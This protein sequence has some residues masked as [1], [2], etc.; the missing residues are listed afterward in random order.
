MSGTTLVSGT[1]A[2]VAGWYGKIPALGDFASRRLPPDFLNAWDAWLQRAFV[3]SRASLREHWQDIYLSSPIWRFALLPG[4]CDSHCW[5]GILMPSI[6]KV[7]RHFPLTIAVA[8]DPQP[9]MIATVFAANDWFTAIEQI[10]LSSLSMD[11]QAVELD[12]Q[13]A[14]M[15]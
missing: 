7:G 15:P 10:A 9:E 5:A 8:L 13:L 12:N 6:D 2:P 3:T 14:A 4:V 11:F 1:A